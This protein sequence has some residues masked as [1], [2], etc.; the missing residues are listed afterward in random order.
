MDE[1]NK[2]STVLAETTFRVTR[3]EL[4]LEYLAENNANLKFPNAE[5]IRRIDLEAGRRLP[6]YQPG[7][8]WEPK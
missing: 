7:A 4:F 1:L 3:L 6:G 5:E 8:K 2:M